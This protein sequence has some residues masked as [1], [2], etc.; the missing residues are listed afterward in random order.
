MK[1][2]IAS[3]GMVALLSAAGIAGNYLYNHMPEDIT[4][5]T[6]QTDTQTGQKEQI[7]SPNIKLLQEQ[8]IDAFT[9]QLPVLMI[10]TGNAQITKENPVWGKMGIYDRENGN[11]ITAEP[12]VILDCSVKLRGAS[13]Y[14]QFDKAQYRIK[15]YREQEGKAFDYPLCG[16]GANSE[17][18]LNGPF[19]D[20]TFIRNSLVYD[21][22]KKC[23]EWA[24][25]NRYVELF[26]DGEYQGVYLA[27]EPVTNG[28]SRLRLSTFGLASGQTAYILKRDRV[29]TEE[30][31]IETWGALNG[32]TRNELSI[33]Y[34][35]KKDLTQQQRAWI[36][37]NVSDF[38]RMLYSDDFEDGNFR[39]EDYID[40]DSFV[41]YFILNEAVL[42]HDA[43][44]LSTYAY[45]ELGGKLA[46]A[47]WDYNNAFDNYQWFAMEYDE[48]Y[49]TDAPWFSQL[50]KDRV[51][52]DKICTRYYE[53]R[54]DILSIDTLYGMI[55]EKQAYLGDAIL[56]NDAVWGY[57]YSNNMLDGE[58]ENGNDRDPASHQEAVEQLKGSIRRRLTFL[59]A[60]IGDL[61]EY[62][63]AAENE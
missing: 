15:F 39:Y 31:A 44:S 6:I 27:V 48:F 46:M 38:E 53:L 13:S 40:V 18:V 57:V 24:P 60:H 16:M 20:K 28:E 32:M 33:S 23:M 52:V 43:G 26:V 49:M 34:P 30:T 42:N 47:V 54:E 1:R 10:D 36:T 12:E 37:E 25:D 11:D 29:G 19:L 5:K 51:F 21:T 50:L 3:L 7:I 22:A 56:R 61:Y 14:S 63:I 59:D 8:G 41:T 62:C 35:S 55:D 4:E 2:I 58:D 45:Q 9:S 17:W